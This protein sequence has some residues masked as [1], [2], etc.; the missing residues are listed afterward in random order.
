[1]KLSQFKTLIREEV[2]KSISNKTKRIAENRTTLTEAQTEQSVLN[3][4]YKEVAK[5]LKKEGFKKKIAPD[6]LKTIA[7]EWLRVTLQSD[8]DHLEE[9]FADDIFENSVINKVITKYYPD[10]DGTF[11]DY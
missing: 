1:M 6:D 10:F 5:Q 4:L 8:D 11:D 9:T 3:I 2:R 7:L